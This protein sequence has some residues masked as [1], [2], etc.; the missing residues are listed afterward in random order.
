MHRACQNSNGYPLALSSYAPTSS[1]M[2]LLQS[3]DRD[4]R[5]CRKGKYLTRSFH[6]I[7]SE[8]DQDKEIYFRN[9]FHELY[10]NRFSAAGHKETS[11]SELK[12]MPNIFGT[13]QRMFQSKI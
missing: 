4:R 1:T 12:Q 2:K 5:L 8:M 7:R 6:S 3:R 9:P 11:S 10:V 13:G